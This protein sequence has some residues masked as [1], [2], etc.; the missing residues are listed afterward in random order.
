MFVYGVMQFPALA[1]AIDELDVPGSCAAAREVLALRD[2]LDAKLAPAIDAVARS[3]EWEVEGAAS[4]VAW[5]RHHGRMAG[6]KAKTLVTTAERMADAPATYVA[7]AEGR[8]SSGQARAIAANVAERHV[9]LFAAHE[10]E[11]VPF[12]EPLSVAQTVAAMAHW[13]ER[14]DALTGGDGEAEHDSELSFSKTFEGRYEQRGSYGPADGAVV[15]TAL[16]LATTSDADTEARTRSAK[17]RR[18]DAMVDIC[19]FFLD[20]QSAVAPG[21][22]HRPHLNVIVGI[23]DL[24]AGLPGSFEDGTPAPSELVESIACDA[25]LHRVLVAG[26]SSILDYGRSVRTAPP[27][28]FNA[29]VLRDGHCRE[30]GCDRTPEWCD[31]H[32]VAMWDE[33]HGPTSLNNM[34]LRCRRHHVLWHKRRKLG[35][36]ERLEPDGTLRITDPGGRSYVSYPDGPAAQRQLLVS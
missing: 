14:A 2:R 16:R 30:P 18:A 34:V 35:W 23:D 21:R 24:L 19:Q 25:N 8:L 28:L 27:D 15:D 9:E 13:A 29:L 26:R 31:A 10:A 36:T 4:M 7:W 3:G 20:H 11:L 1:A 5:L 12:L 22:R 33:D 6:G 32:H 17:E